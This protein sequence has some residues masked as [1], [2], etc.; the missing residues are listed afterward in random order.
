MADSQVPLKLRKQMLVMRAA[1][2]RVELAQH[3][4]DVRRAATVS[5]IVRNALPGQRSQGVASRAFD[6][7]KRFPLL[8]TAASLVA[9][10]FKLPI[11][12]VATKWGGAASVGY[13]LWL[14]WQKHRAETAGIASRSAVVPSARVRR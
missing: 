3:V 1:V 7:L 12:K 6:L 14:L 9:S 2:E 5:A 13:K 10:R 8:A 4:L 11:L